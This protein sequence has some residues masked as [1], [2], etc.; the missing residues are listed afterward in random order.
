MSTAPLIRFE[1]LHLAFGDNS[2]YEGLSLNVYRGQTLAVIGG[3]GCGK[4]VLLKCLIGLMYPDSGRVF[5]E[6]IEVSQLSEKQLRAIRKDIAMVFQGAALFDSLSVG[7]NLAYP[8][9]EHMPDLSEKEIAVRVAQTL[10][11]VNL[12]G[13]ESMQPVELSGGMRKRVG[14]ARAIMTTPKV[15]LWDE[16]TTGLDP[17]STQ[18]IDELI[19]SMKRHLGCTSIV[20]THDMNSVFRVSDGIAMLA[21]RKIIASGSVAEMRASSHPDVRAFFGA[22]E[23][24]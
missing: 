5:Y 15:I 18:V 13:I 4:S 12:S 11:L 9:R 17:I 24:K 7:E 3:S 20:V 1:D 10:E 23:N 21:R 2:I 14:L 6:D 19:I 8:L 16:P 22:G